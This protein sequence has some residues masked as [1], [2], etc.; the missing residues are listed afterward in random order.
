MEPKTIT[1]RKYFLD[2][3]R[4]IA[5]GLLILFHTGCL[6]A[7]WTYNLKSPRLLPELEWFLLA[8]SP[9]RMALLFLIS[10][11]A[12][13]S[14]VDKIG[15]GG[16]ALDRLRRLVPVLLVGMFVV[17]PPQ[18]YI[19]LVDRGLTH[20]S[21]WHF[22]IFSY[23]AFDQT[24]VAPLHKTM[25]TYDHLWFLAYL[26]VY[27]LLF[28]LVMAVVRLARQGRSI[29]PARLPTWFVLA[30]PGLWLILTT[31][32]M[33]RIWPQTFWIGNDWGSHLKWAGM[34]V[35]GAVLAHHDG[36]WQWL[37]R[38]RLGLLATAVVCLALQSLNRVF[39]LTGTA[40][41]LWSAIGWSAASGAYAWAMICALCGYAAGWFNRPSA[42][43]SH[44]NEA[45]LPV[46]VLHQPIL[47]IAA[48]FIFPRHW[49]LPLE[50]TALVFITALG[51]LS[52]YEVLIR[53]FAVTRFLFGLRAKRRLD[54]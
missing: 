54:G 23:L 5:F 37:Q 24:L 45:I 50:I 33:E 40:D 43:L 11:V 9:W 10:G 30:A 12:A 20:D 31:F 42:L 22:W 48:W 14:L 49:P 4:V 25:P 36:G 32:A 19:Q 39:Y 53:P 44:L 8:L 3:L 17:I 7:S 41:P 15:A 26:L 27:A 52:I 1:S 35:I 47:L 51:S 6:Y 21:Y 16:F 34:F 13:R 29:G 38:H 18:T 28:A 2:W 46:Y